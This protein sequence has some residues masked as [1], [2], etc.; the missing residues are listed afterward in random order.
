MAR[1]V[2]SNAELLRIIAGVDGM[3][4]RQLAGTP[5]PNQVPH[6]PVLLSAARTAH[7]LLH[8]TQNAQGEAPGDTR[9]L[10]IGILKEGD[11]IPGIDPRVVSCIRAAAKRFEEL[12][13]EVTEVSVPEHTQT[14]IIGRAYR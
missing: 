11:M 10:R 9:R 4:D 12:G 5:F 3:D 6:Y 8:A 14:P 7:A 13:A 2:V 1:D